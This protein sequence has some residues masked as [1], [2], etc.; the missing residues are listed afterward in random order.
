MLL[1]V[2]SI[3]PL[4][5]RILIVTKVPRTNVPLPVKG[6]EGV[7]PIAAIN[8][9]YVGVNEK[10]EKMYERASYSSFGDCVALFA[11]GAIQFSKDSLEDVMYSDYGTS[12]ASPIVAGVAA[13][14][15]SEDSETQY[16]F[17]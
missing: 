2:D 1:I 8:N 9:R 3:F 5:K 17:E 4:A 7:I 10:L 13:T 16:N 12:F 11:P 6:Y 14:L 15:M